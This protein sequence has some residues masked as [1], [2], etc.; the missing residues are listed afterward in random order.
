MHSIIHMKQC[1]IG[2]FEMFVFVENPFCWR[3]SAGKYIP[4]QFI[5]CSNL[6]MFY[7]VRSRPYNNT[8]KDPTIR[9]PPLSKHFVTVRNW[10]CWRF[11]PFHRM[12]PPAEPGEGYKYVRC[13]L[14]IQI[15]RVSNR[16]LQDLIK[17]TLDTL[18]SSPAE[19]TVPFL[20]KELP[21]TPLACFLNTDS[22]FTIK[23]VKLLPVVWVCCLRP[24]Y[25]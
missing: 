22:T 16:F 20:L 9:W 15:R 21:F 10:F 6:N 11:H 23:S 18:P 1:A 7:I 4:V 12:K 19:A 13:L 3:V 8:V 24:I 2:I 14:M 5:L 17:L 25:G